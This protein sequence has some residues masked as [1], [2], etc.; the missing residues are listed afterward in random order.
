MRIK[1]FKVE[2]AEK[3]EGLQDCTDTFSLSTHS[4]TSTGCTPICSASSAMKTTARTLLSSLFSCAVETPGPA[5]LRSL[6]V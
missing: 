4:S 5:A 2:I 1:F 3:R 6:R